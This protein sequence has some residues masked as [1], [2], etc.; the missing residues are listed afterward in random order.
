[1]RR[2]LI[3]LAVLGT[4]TAVLTGGTGLIAGAGLTSAVAA[5]APRCTATS[6]VVV[7]VDF[8]AWDGPTV[9]ACA[10]TPTT[11][12]QALHQVGFSTSGTAHDGPG[13]VCRIASGSFRG[14]AAL[15]S[16]AQQACVRTPPSSAY[17]S[18]W[19]ADRAQS[20]WHYSSL[21]V[22]SYSPQPGSVDAW[23][24][25]AGTPPRVAPGA[26]RASGAPAAP[27]TRSGAVPAPTGRPAS[28]TP[29]P[30]A[31]V[32][33]IPVQPMPARRSGIP[34]RRALRT[35][36]AAATTSAASTANPETSAT[37]AP[38]T[39]SPPL[40]SKTGSTRRTIT[41]STR[42]VAT[43]TAA[44]PASTSGSASTS[45]STFTTTIASSSATS[46]TGPS[47]TVID[48]TST[49]TARHSGSSP[50]PAVLGGAL[51]LALAAGA[52]LTFWRRRQLG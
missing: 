28:T 30:T 31:S 35:G 36:Q 9:R 5:G 47:P 14:G 42:S 11:G 24:F 46:T 49:A 23:T 40:G 19:H 6:G 18:Y 20:S 45:T 26:L 25:G 43:T 17:W 16:T 39:V 48:A 44:P 13:F 52:A 27:P 22:A 41:G 32:A 33:T 12:L 21:G 51:V 34:P 3:A 8:G 38:R 15:P 50:W 4:S 2:L 37:S 7:A 10:S 29:T 1:M